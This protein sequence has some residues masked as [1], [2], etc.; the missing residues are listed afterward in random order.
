MDGTFELISNILGDDDDIKQEDV[1][2]NGANAKD[3]ATFSAQQP[4]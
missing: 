1:A 2:T 4:Q 3:H